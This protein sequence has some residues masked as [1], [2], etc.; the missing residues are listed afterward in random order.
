MSFGPRE[1]V[2]PL[3]STSQTLVKCLFCVAV[4]LGVTCTA[5]YAQAEIW[6]VVTVLGQR[7]SEGNLPGSGG[8]V[9]A[10]EIRQHNYDDVNRALRKIPGVYLRE[11]DGFGLFPNISLRGVDTNRSSKV[12]IMEDGIPSAPAPYSAPEAYYSPTTGRMSKIEILKGS[13]QVKYGPHTTGGVVN[14]VSTPIPDQREFYLKTIGGNHGELRTHGYYGD[15]IDTEFGRFGILLE[16]Y[17]RSNNGFKDLDSTAENDGDSTGFQKSE[18]M[19][20]L[21]WES[22][23]EAETYQRLEAKFGYSDIDADES[24]LGLTE[25]DFDANPFR[26]YAATRFDNLQTENVRT[27]L[28]YFREIGE[29][30]SLSLTGYYTE[31]HRDWAKL[32]N[33]GGGSESNLSEAIAA[34]GTSLSI[35]KGEAAGTLNVRHNKRDYET[36]GFK[37]ATNIDFQLG[38]TDHELEIGWGIHYD[39][40]R[41]KQNT[42][43]YTQD[44]NGNITGVTSTAPGTAGNRR[45][46]S[47][48][49]FAYVKDSFDVG[50]FTFTPGFRYEKVNYEFIDFDTSGANPDMI[51]QR[52]SSDISAHAGGLGVNYE[53]DEQTSFFG[54]IHQGYSVPGPRD[55]ARSGLTEETSLTKEVGVRYRSGNQAFQ[56]ELSY[57]HTSFDDLLVVDNIGGA[58]T[59]DSENV[60]EAISQGIEFKAQYDVGIAKQKDYKNPFYVA[61]TFTNAELDGDSNST[62]AES[63]FAGGKDGNKIPYVP[64]FQ[65]S[66]G[67][68]IETDR[69]GV[70]VDGIYVDETFS[71]A[72]NTSSQIRPD[73]TPDARFGKTDDY[74]IIDLSGYYKI[75]ENTKLLASIH[76]LTDREYVVS[77]HPH[78]PRPGKPFTVT[79][80]IEVKF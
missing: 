48:S 34:G 11:E 44:A 46:D 56:T 18:P 19:L 10:E 62:D 25:A 70:F 69:W 51:T 6:D 4:L 13:S 3:K 41:R 32:H 28:N 8:S 78:G 60:G 80:G 37:T 45:Q 39:Y 52:A 33:I 35:L 26:R 72:S 47:D 64:E 14:Y 55:N 43:I 77:R 63:I 75:N 36:Y 2:P 59:G 20:K 12:T 50:P 40:I 65:F 58:G 74:F 29:Q 68:G 38:E 21:S 23:E 22:P 49:F 73:G 53:F 42:D 15:V 61:F 67:T 27:S 5:Q 16:E 30:I 24:Y 76:N 79:G 31:F 57:F 9:S 66:V 71:T 7:E 17:F 54:G 1:F